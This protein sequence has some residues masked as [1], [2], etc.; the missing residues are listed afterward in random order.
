M[1]EITTGTVNTSR[2][3]P[4]LSHYGMAQ[5][6]SELGMLFNIL[7]FQ[8][9]TNR[10]SGTIPTEF[11]KMV[12]MWGLSMENSEL[13][14]TIPMELESLVWNGALDLVLLGGNQLTGMIPEGLCSLNGSYFGCGNG[15]CGCTCACNETFAASNTTA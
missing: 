10:I 15:L 13:T 6:P 14:G 4:F 11:G 7:V 3:L 2:I 5:L 12:G 9:S 8:S 1:S